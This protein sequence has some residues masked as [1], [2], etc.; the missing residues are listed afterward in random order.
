MMLVED[1]VT[2]KTH[3]M[4][5]KIHNII[6]VDWRVTERYIQEQRGSSLETL[7]FNLVKNA[8]SL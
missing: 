7:Y 6:I 1:C 2:D 5:N 4:V 8:Y 3:E